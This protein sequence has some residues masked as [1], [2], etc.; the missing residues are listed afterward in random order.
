MIN[1]MP[2]D[3]RK[4]LAASRANSIILRYILLMSIVIAVV[5]VEV[6]LVYLMLRN[7]KGLHEQAI[8]DS[9]KQAAAYM[10]IQNDAETFKKNLAISKYIL[11]RQIPYTDL[12]FAVANAL[13]E[14]ATIDTLSLVPT[15]FGTP[16]TMTVNISG[17]Y[18][19]AIAVKSALQQAKYKN[20]LLF[21]DSVS[22]VSLSSPESDS[23]KQSSTAVYNIT[24]SKSILL[25]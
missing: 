7:E 20:R 18:N 17:G 10:S 6:A 11:D 15:S 14:G 4:Q 24:Y 23:G 1:L 2:P 21:G 25:Q 8:A 22:F 3:N 13:P 12:I 9:D 16:T 5:V 19:M